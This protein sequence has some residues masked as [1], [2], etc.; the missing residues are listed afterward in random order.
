[1]SS[2]ETQA[3]PSPVTSAAEA[4]LPLSL[5]IGWS[6]GSL[7]S[8]TLLNAIGATQLFFFV[9]ILGMRPAIAGAIIFI[10]KI[11]DLMTDPPMGLISDRTQTR[12]GRRRPWMFAGA[13]ISGLAFY[14]IYNPPAVTGNTMVAVQCVFLLLYATGYTMFNVP[15][16][17]M[18]AEMTDGYH[19][20]S[21]LISF[22]VVFQSLGIV[23]GNILALQLIKFGGSGSQGYA[24]MGQVI[25]FAITVPMLIAVFSTAKARRSER[26]IEQFSLRQQ[27]AAVT[28]N[29]PFLVLMGAKLLQLFGVAS[30]SASILF[31][32][33][34]VLGR[35]E[36]DLALK[37]GVPSLLA[38]LAFMPIWLAVGRRIGKRNTW[39]L[40]VVL[41]V[42]TSLSFALA[43]PLE[44][45]LIFIARG[46][47]FGLCTG[48][49][50]LMAQSM[51]PDTM[52]Y[53]ARRS[54][55][56]RE[57][58]FS[59]VYSAVEKLA[60]ALAPFVIGI[61]LETMGFDKSVAVQNADAQFAIVFGAAVLPAIG[62]GLSIPVLLLYDLTQEKLQA[63][64]RAANS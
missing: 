59:G 38:T 44:P 7:G 5:A 48:G 19:E 24:L 16:V 34:S 17:A 6:V 52:E 23:T 27:I 21:R 64:T 49:I 63:T 40:A 9:T 14:L 28:G 8:A 58:V 51:L 57:G 37:F 45:D 53:D 36:G 18:P 39:L 33:K 35:N 43:T 54:G 11:Y 62:F 29:R 1:M 26:D 41:F 50:L 46:A 20:R 25:A 10:S 12:W 2:S 15:Y 13:L 55:R 42:M 4:R 56:R 22:R 30:S 61:L 47:L 3:T 32:I 60:F 31:L